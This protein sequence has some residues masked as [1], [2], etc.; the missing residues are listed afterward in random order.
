MISLLRFFEEFSWKEEVFVF[1]VEV[2][3]RVVD[4][5]LMGKM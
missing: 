1:F 5:M 4:F 2:F 3:F